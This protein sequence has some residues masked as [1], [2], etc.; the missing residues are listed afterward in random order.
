MRLGFMV[1]GAA[2]LVAGVYIYL[3]PPDGAQ[4][5]LVTV[6]VATV[7]GA[8]FGAWAASMI[9]VSVPNVSLKRFEAALGEGHVLLMVD[10]PKDRVEEIQELVHRRH[11]EA[12]DHGLEPTIPVFP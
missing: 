7:V 8:L 10:V 12:S 9:G 3:T 11:P 6:L 5:Q 1:G 4:L 2:G